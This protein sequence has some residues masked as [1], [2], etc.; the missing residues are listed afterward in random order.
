MTTT[1]PAAAT[2]LQQMLGGPTATNLIYT[3]VELDLPDLINERPATAERLAAARGADPGALRRVLRGLAALGILAGTPDGYVLTPLGDLLRRDVPGSMFHSAR[4]MGHP[5]T[6][7]A[8]TGLA[9]AARTG[10]TA[11]DHVHGMDFFTYM[12][13]DAD[14]ADRF[15]RFMSDVTDQVARTVAAHYDFGDAKSIVD[16][17]GGA[18][19]LLRAVLRANPHAH[20]TVLDVGM[21]RAQADEAIA[22]DGL[23]DRCAFVEGDFFTEVPAGADVYVLKSVLHDWDDDRASRVLATVRS[24]MAPHSRLLVVERELPD[25]GPPPFDAVMSDLI[26]LTMAPGQERTA[27][28]YQALLRRAGLCLEAATPTPGGPTIFE[29]RPA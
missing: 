4:L 28:E 16:V 7:R 3:A 27:G 29:A 18:G 19:A 23:A 6:Q 15:N 22:A 24:A 10:R 20:G 12:M 17:G 13:G 26:M 8:W 2:A 25:S 14:F 21:L 9:Y 11:F 1:T 5:A